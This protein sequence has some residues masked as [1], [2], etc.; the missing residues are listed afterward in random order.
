[1]GLKVILEQLRKWKTKIHFLTYASL[2]TNNFLLV[3]PEACQLL[4][5]IQDCDCPIVQCCLFLIDELLP[6]V[7]WVFLFL[8]VK[9]IW[10]NLRLLLVSLWETLAVSKI[11]LSINLNKGKEMKRQEKKRRVSLRQVL[12]YGNTKILVIYCSLTS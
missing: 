12:S 6:L 9:I 11:L 3:S 1:M 10:T 7:S 8:L 5:N 2:I 4:L